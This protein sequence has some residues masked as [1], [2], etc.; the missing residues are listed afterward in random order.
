MPLRHVP[1]ILFVAALLILPAVSSQVTRPDPA[2]EEVALPAE[3]GWR[4][5]LVYEGDAGIWTVKTAQ[6]FERFGAPEIIGLDDR[7]R[8]TVLVSYSGKWTPFQTVTD[9][10]W[11]GALAHVDLDPHRPGRE[12]YTGGLSGTLYQIHPRRDRGFDCVIPVRLRG[13][14][15]HTFAA[16]DLDP[17]REG[18]ELL[19]F[20]RAGRVLELRPPGAAGGTWSTR[21]V[22]ELP[23]RVRD[24][25]VLPDPRTGGARIAAAS[26]AGTVLLG[27]LRE[28]LF[29]VQ[30]ILEEPM[31]FGRLAAGGNGPAVLYAARD[32]GVVVRLEEG[33]DGS[34]RRTVVYTGPQGVRGLAAGRFHADPDVE[35]LAVFGYSGKVQL[36]T[37]E[38]GGPWSVETLFKDRDKGHWLCKGELDGRNTTEELVGSGYG[39]RIFM[40][41]RPP[42]YGLP[43]VPTEA[44]SDESAEERKKGA[45]SRPRQA[46]AGEDGGMR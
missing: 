24:A 46:D 27:R 32:D 19:V 15:L 35:C 7:G 40:L 18:N 25:R 22:A 16:G 30:P 44:D 5:S 12:L 13:R 1:R 37:R 31:G 14:E 28:G 33:A 4:A 43:G 20:T 6:V 41:A 11:L 3:G 45:A 42:G 2:R 34:W 9:N 23:G 29:R 10:A 8:C 36:L 39:K 38:P 17:A 21:P 26:R